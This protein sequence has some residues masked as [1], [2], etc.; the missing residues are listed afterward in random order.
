ME[1]ARRTDV[2]V[3]G[4]NTQF[5][6]R[7]Q[8]CGPLR[9]EPAGT[10][11]YMPSAIFEMTRNI[12]GKY[13]TYF[14]MTGSLVCG[15]KVQIIMS[16]VPIWV[17]VKVPPGTTV[18]SFQSVIKT[19]LFDNELRSESTEVRKLRPFK[20]FS[21]EKVDF[22]VVRFLTARDRT[23][24]IDWCD[25]IVDKKTLRKRCEIVDDDDT[26]F[27]L[28]ARVLGFPTGNWCR[29]QGVRIPE[30]EFRALG[31]TN[32]DEA[33]LCS[34]KSFAGCDWTDDDRTMLVSWDIETH[35]VT[36]T[37]DAPGPKD[38]FTIVSIGATAHFK[39][40]SDTLVTYCGSLMEAIPHPK[41][42]IGRVNM[43]V[44][45]DNERQLL[46]S[47]IEFLRAIR[48]DVLQAYNGG[49]YDWPLVREKLK[50]YGL[51]TQLYSAL[52]T[53]IPYHPVSE[54][55]VY[56]YNFKNER[57]KITAEETV[58]LLVAQFPGVIDTDTMVVF[59]QLYPTA[60][61]G[62]GQ[63]L[64]HYLKLNGIEGKE[65]M[66]YKRL[67]RIYELSVEIRAHCT[68][69]VDRSA[70]KFRHTILD[71]YE[72]WVERA[73]ERI[74]MTMGTCADHLKVQAS[75][76]LYYNIIDCYRT[77][78]LYAIQTIIS[79]RRAFASRSFT[80]LYD[81]FYRANGVKVQNLV[82]HHCATNGFAYSNRSNDQNVKH[83]YP[84]AIVFKP[85]KG[86]HNEDPTT[87][88]D[89]SSLYPSVQRAHNIS[90]DKIVVVK[91]DLSSDPAA[92][93]AARAFVG[94]LLAA[95]YTLW[96]IE[97][98]TNTGVEVE[99]YTVRHNGNNTLTTEGRKV[100][101]H[102]EKGPDG[103]L[104]KKGGR[105][106]PVYGRDCLPGEC[107]GIMPYFLDILFNVRAQ[108]K[109][110]FGPLS[111]LKEK[112]AKLKDLP[113]NHG[114]SPV[115]YLTDVDFKD[116]GMVLATTI[117]YEQVSNSHAK[118]NS[119]QKAV[120]LLMNTVYGVS[121]YFKSP[122]Y[123]LPVAGG[124]TQYGRATITRV[125]QFCTDL[126]FR[127]RYGDSVTGD[128]PILVKC[129]DD[130][131]LAR[132]IPISEIE[133]T[134]TTRDDGKEVA[135]TNL[136]VW[137]DKAWTRI[138]RI[139]R[140]KTK[141][142]IYR[143]TTHHG[144]VDV[145]G[146]HS[147]LDESA[148]KIQPKDLKI[149]DRLL[150]KRP[151]TGDWKWYD[152]WTR[153]GIHTD[154]FRE[155]IVGGRPVGITFDFA[156]KLA[157]ANAFRELS[158]VLDRY[159]SIGTNGDRF[160]ITMTD[161]PSSDEVVSIEC[162]GTTDD[163]V[164]DLETENHHFGAGIG[165]MIV[166]NTDSNYLGCPERLFAIIR[167]L[168]NRHVEYLE[169]LRAR[170]GLESGPHPTAYT[171]DDR[172][173]VSR[174]FDANDKKFAAA[175]K[176]GNTKHADYQSSEAPWTEAVAALESVIASGDAVRIESYIEA[177]R[178]RERE[179]YWTKMVQITRME[180]ERLRVEVNDHLAEYNGTEYIAMAYE[181]VLHPAVLTGKK[182]YFGYPHMNAENFHPE[183]AE[184]FIKGVD[185][186]KQGQTALAK[187]YGFS[188]IQQILSVD[189]YLDIL[190][191]V[192]S[193]LRDLVSRRFDTSVFVKQSKYK[194]PRDGKP[195]NIAIQKFI[196]RMRETKARIERSGDLERAALYRMPEVGD[197]F[198]YVI[199]TRDVEYDVRGNK[200]D[201]S[202][203][204][205]C[206]EFVSVYEASQK[207]DRPLVI[208][209]NYYMES[210]VFG[211]F[212]RFISYLPQ[213]EP[214]GEFD[215]D[216]KEEYK[217]YDEK[218]IKAAKKFII[219]YCKGLSAAPVIPMVSDSTRFKR[220]YKHVSGVVTA[221]SIELYGP[222]ASWILYTYDFED[223]TGSVVEF[224][225][226]D[227]FERA[228]LG[229][230]YRM[231]VG[232][233][234]VRPPTRINSVYRDGLEHVF[235]NV[236]RPR[237]S[238]LED[239]VVSLLR[240]VYAVAKSARESLGGFII[241]MRSVTAL[242]D[243]SFDTDVD[244]VCRI[245]GDSREDLESF[246]EAARRLIAMYAVR[247]SFS[248]HLNT[249]K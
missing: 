173:S 126:G 50:S 57:V 222:L 164:Y 171:K 110:R 87:A 9:E 10:V 201:N 114:K 234:T 104:V 167:Q 36:L 172:I 11:T 109:K 237:I 77:Q 113:E 163:Y 179:D 134:W 195:G 6:N 30:A 238:Q 203:T 47:F 178:S 60:E 106:V 43:I 96:K 22:V 151:H 38:H 210:A 119:D 155:W 141:S 223:R 175:I 225:G 51:L 33:W 23:K 227:P 157:A 185:I 169:A 224:K 139:I 208:D 136:H 122:L 31:I 140:H 97:F 199:V 82:G 200:I 207:T 103:K 193:K 229:A 248:H 28:V 221:R 228:M 83:K 249:F 142:L 121:G 101:S 88:L 75:L 18:S 239:R 243:A 117:T 236:I 61:V 64:N 145:T 168:H 161:I 116:T 32:V 67:H 40:T 105:L 120:K 147:L 5:P 70:C 107:M 153:L 128:T 191:I 66:Y 218:I 154:R 27:P 56:K 19:Q 34:A 17:T 35:S 55:S 247:H 174:Y 219:E 42:S 244:E 156:D 206:M 72:K 29:A 170:F 182:K 13:A 68:C 204:S 245:D 78:Q 159:P 184:L 111:K 92:I 123:L 52:S 100:I 84:G 39:E 15:R 205:E 79:D 160:V 166:H 242:D 246:C 148:N 74:P 94:R 202:S 25:D 150:H 81:A 180:I 186:I 26:L 181:E 73:A 41:H 21:L 115:D 230:L 233:H 187:E 146:E 85:E 213:F 7:A 125:Y 4:P 102:Y 215:L 58:N 162:L 137:S 46:V 69:S 1:I 241:Y 144:C 138:V 198:Q 54:E 99:A 177:L 37:G 189:N 235:M 53:V 209:F 118:L 48:P 188:T 89:A 130:G 108:I 190:T 240:P 14:S 65:D 211:I 95:G 129:V 194:L 8:F 76:L 165:E 112:F 131:M 135:A 2:V 24:F 196:K 49:N 90:P 152:G 214:P 45:C 63:S 127:V 16:E 220:L 176:G 212:A 133:D 91:D 143:V 197:R 192:K 149:G 71:Y 59:K 44:I 80:S 158:T 3:F 86:L 232:G 217:K 12:R 20:G 231:A 93:E 216:D 62:R 98:V 132:C 183:N 226:R 124:T